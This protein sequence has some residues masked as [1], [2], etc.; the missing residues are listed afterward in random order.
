MEAQEMSDREWRIL[1][2]VAVGN[3]VT[4]EDDPPS[5]QLA[6]GVDYPR[7]LELASRNR[8]VPALSRWLIENGLED[9]PPRR[10]SG[11]MEGQRRL[12]KHRA[13]HLTAEA[14]R[15]AAALRAA[16]VTFA[17]TKGIVFQTELYE[18]PET[19]E[20]NDIDAM[21][22]L[23]DAQK[24]AE[25][26]AGLGYQQNR[27]FSDLDGHLVD[28]PRADLLMYKLSPDHSPHLMRPGPDDALPY[29]AVD[30]AHS[31]TWWESQWTIPLEEVLSEVRQARIGMGEDSVTVPALSHVHSFLFA[32]LHLFREAWFERTSLGKDVNLSQFADIVRYWS[33]YRRSL[34]G[35]LGD[36]IETHVL[37]AP[38][39]WVLHHTDELFG[40]K[41][42]HDLGLDTHAGEEWVSSA[43]AKNGETLRWS[44]DMTDR[45][46][47]GFPA[48]LGRA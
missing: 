34:A 38:V 3:A 25:A 39:A 5:D 15:V 42:V 33:L 46:Q 10:M 12:S 11:L 6:T 40:T 13:R 16:G 44:G 7:L 21:M 43:R 14:G 4:A 2:R 28:M 9:E 8:L 23:R 19:R 36:V 24:A 37:F 18:A 47:R 45:L 31:L 41:I 35:R 26:L 17:F 20:L 32:A 30:L 27:T 1:L 22:S 48:T 29:I